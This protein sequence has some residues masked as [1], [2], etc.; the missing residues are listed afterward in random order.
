MS[1]DAITA[2]DLAAVEEGAMSV[3]QAVEF[4]GDSERRIYQLMDAGVLTWFMAG[5]HR[6]ITRASV[7]RYLA[8]LVAQ[9]RVAPT[10]VRTP[11]RKAKTK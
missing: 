4:T 5:S 11:T 1:P 9:H 7:R 2:D 3:A 8:A 10:R 6:R